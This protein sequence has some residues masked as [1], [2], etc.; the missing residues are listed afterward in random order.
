M[1]KSNCDNAMICECCGA[2]MAFGIVPMEVLYG[3]GPSQI[4]II[5]HIPAWTCAACQD[6]ISAEGAEIAEHN[7]ICDHLGRLQSHEIKAIRD[8]MGLSQNA[9]AL[10]MRV[11]RVTMAR[12][13]GGAQVQSAGHN[14]AMVELLANFRARKTVARPY[15]YQTDVKHREAASMLFELRVA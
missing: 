9:F 13:E 8:E 3:A 15:V 4:S 5:A 1:T 14:D 7:A 10:R 12:W 11:S 2:A 6:V